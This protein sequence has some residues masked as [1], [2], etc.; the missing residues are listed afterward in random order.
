[1][2]CITNTSSATGLDKCSF[3]LRVQSATNALLHTPPSYSRPVIYVAAICS[4]QAILPVS[5]ILPYLQKKKKKTHFQKRLSPICTIC[6]C[7]FGHTPWFFGDRRPQAQTSDTK[8]EQQKKAPTI[9]QISIKNS[10]GWQNCWKVVIWHCS[11][12]YLH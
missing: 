10:N 8:S 9:K 1:M 11:S 12:L 4:V 3:T 2:S 6:W 7:C 5:A